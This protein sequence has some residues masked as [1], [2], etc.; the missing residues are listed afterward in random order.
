MRFHPTP[1]E[2]VTLVE[3]QSHRDERGSFARAF[4]RTVFAAAGIQF[5]VRQT[6]ISTNTSTGTLRGLHY[7]TLPHSEAKLVRCVRGRVF[8]VVV[9]LRP[10]SPTFLVWHGVEL[11][12]EGGLSLY[13][14]TGVAHGFLTLEADS[15]LH[16]MMDADHE[17]AAGAGL[18]WND[19]AVGIAWPSA[20]A[21]ISPRDAS[22]PDFRPCPTSS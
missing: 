9:D 12:P 20:P 10:G 3:P 22:Y 5:E 16:Y 19:P 11:S 7:Q 15:D 21:V 18:R 14:P 2:G 4:C 13:I 1:I 17:P 8:D 6:S